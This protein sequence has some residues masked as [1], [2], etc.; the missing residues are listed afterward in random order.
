MLQYHQKLKG[1]VF[2]HCSLEFTPNQ[3]KTLKKNKHS[4][5]LEMLHFCCQLA[6]LAVAHVG[7][8][9]SKTLS[10]MDTG[11]RGG[12]GVSK[13]FSKPCSAASLDVWEKRLQDNLLCVTTKAH[14]PQKRD[15][16]L[17][18]APPINLRVNARSLPV[19][20]VPITSY[21]RTVW[22]RQEGWKASKEWRLRGQ[23]RHKI[24][25]PKKFSY[26]DFFFYDG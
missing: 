18:F 13:G 23:Y 24:V 4:F 1:A 12:G 8:P 25:A 19:G 17:W 26:C 5:W 20:L 15:D 10:Q 6:K 11:G 7:Q 16:Q 21:E 9:P 2:A 3:K 14:S 22:I